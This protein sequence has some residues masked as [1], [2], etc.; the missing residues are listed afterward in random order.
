MTDTTHDLCARARDVYTQDGTRAVFSRELWRAIG[1]VTIE[2]R[3]LMRVLAR[4]KCLCVAAL[5][6]RALQ[7]L[8]VGLPCG[9][10]LRR[11]GPHSWRRNTLAFGTMFGGVGWT[12]FVHR[13][14]LDGLEG[15]M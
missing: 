10:I 6:L 4:L 3:T 12:L 14:A 8:V 1:A 7:A 9:L 2:V 13:C 11:L 5:F 15:F